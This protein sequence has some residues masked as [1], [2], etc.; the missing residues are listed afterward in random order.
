MMSHQTSP[1]MCV[2]YSSINQTR[3]YPSSWLVVGTTVKGRTHS[4]P[5]VDQ[6]AGFACCWLLLRARIVKDRRT[7]LALRRNE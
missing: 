2:C 6:M 1:F 3:A 7:T 5:S 4:G